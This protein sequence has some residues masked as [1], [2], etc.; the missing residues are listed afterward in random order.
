MLPA[1]EE[2]SIV[3]S[4]ELL[5]KLAGLQVSYAIF[6]HGYKK[7]LQDSAEAEEVFVKKVFIENLDQVTALSPMY[8]RTP[9]DKV[10]LFNITYQKKNCVKF[11]L[12]MSSKQNMQY[13]LTYTYM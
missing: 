1:A 8:F 12:V 5:E 2:Q 6:L 4:D 13:K 9:I 11:F 7:V 3:P 10:S